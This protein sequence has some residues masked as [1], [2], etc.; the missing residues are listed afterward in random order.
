ME[1]WYFVRPIFKEADLTLGI[2]FMSIWTCQREPSLVK[3]MCWFAFEME[4]EN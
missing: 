2:V 4:A 3:A 1:S